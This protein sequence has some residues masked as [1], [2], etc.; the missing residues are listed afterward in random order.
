M[1]RDNGMVTG[2]Q[3]EASV[4]MLET[5]RSVNE[6]FDP[7]REKRQELVTKLKEALGAK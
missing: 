5:E 4:K 1:L 3:Y 2:E 6:A 7:E